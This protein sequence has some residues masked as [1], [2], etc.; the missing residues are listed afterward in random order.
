MQKFQ[1][2]PVKQVRILL[3]DDLS[4]CA[5]KEV[6]LVYYKLPLFQLGD[7][8]ENNQ[9]V[10]HILAKNTMDKRSGSLPA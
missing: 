10:S 3:Q 6:K 4:H 1:L 8:K 5:T 2:H 9:S 7:Q